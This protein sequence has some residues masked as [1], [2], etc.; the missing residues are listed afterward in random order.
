MAPLICFFFA[1]YSLSSSWTYFSSSSCRWWNCS[2]RRSLFMC[3]RRRPE[4]SL[5][6]SKFSSYWALGLTLLSREPKPPLP[7]LRLP[8]SS[9]CTV[10]SK[11]RLAM[12]ARSLPHW[13][14]LSDAAGRALVAGLPLDLQ[15]LRLMS[16]LRLCKEVIGSLSLLT[17]VFARCTV[18]TW[19]FQSLHRSVFSWGCLVF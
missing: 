4:R 6:A 12:L 1:S 2:M 10:C 11:T 13:T 5:H 15:S 8:R 18:R 3:L 14:S 16:S 9:T 19:K 17:S 7:P